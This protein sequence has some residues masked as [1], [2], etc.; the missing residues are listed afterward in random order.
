[1]FNIGYNCVTGFNYK[2]WS[3]REL[4]TYFRG[5]SGLMTSIVRV[6]GYNRFANSC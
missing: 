5:M 3:I 4:M 2:F 1:M 6:N